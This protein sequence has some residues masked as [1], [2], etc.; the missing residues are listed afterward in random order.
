MVERQLTLA[1]A[2]QQ[3]LHLHEQLAQEPAIIIIT[4]QELPM[5]AIL[6]FDAYKKMQETLEAQAK[7]LEILQ[8]EKFM[9]AFRQIVQGSNTEA[10]LSLDEIKSQLEQDEDT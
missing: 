2:H 4:Q 7:T 10:M 1:E 3:F 6:P 5:L 9:A 8:D